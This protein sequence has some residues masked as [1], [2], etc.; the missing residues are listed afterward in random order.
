MYLNIPWNFIKQRPQFLAEKLNNYTELV[1]YY[2]KPYRKTYIVK[3]ENANNLNIVSRYKIPRKCK[4]LKYIDNMIQ[5]IFLFP[6]ITRYDYIW[7]MHIDQYDILKKF[8]K[9]KVLIYDC[10]DDYINFPS[11]TKKEK[12]SI[13]KLENEL[14]N[15]AN[16]VFYSSASL[17]E[18]HTLRY[19]YKKNSYVINN[20]FEE[21]DKS[22]E[23]TTEKK[24][25]EI[26]MNNIKGKKIT[27][28]GAIEGWFDF[29][30]IEKLLNR[31]KKI[32]IVL[33]GPTSLNI[34]KIER[35]Y[36]FGKI[37]HNS[38]NTA[39][40]YSDALIMPFKI[41]ELILSVDPIKVY[42]YIS[43]GKKVIVPNYPEMY[44]FKNFVD[45][46]NNI[47]SLIEIVEK[48][49]DNKYYIDTRD[50]ISKN[51]WEVRAKEIVRIIE[52]E[53]NKNTFD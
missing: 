37:E 13:L 25:I 31:N 15:K 19:G 26:Y 45:I 8:V 50:F 21:F 35:L 1:V 46:Y 36:L 24:D 14:V 53:E 39:M 40:K 16:Y 20:A 23:E 3:K 32:S 38:V 41:N 51:T 49:D 28:V 30:I 47:E 17:K 34:P 2:N 6:Y 9:N 48:L 29:D 18:S 44:K 22:D 5:F 12:K 52:N 10:M 43:S 27:Y 11:A 42:E 7:I 4:L 33:F